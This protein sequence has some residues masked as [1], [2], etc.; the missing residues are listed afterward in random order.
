MVLIRFPDPQT[1]R[2]A[3]GFLSRHF[4]GKTWSSGQTLV[5]EAAIAHLKAEGIPFTIEGPATYE[6]QA[7]T[8]RNPPAA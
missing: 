8:V 6:Q 3:L 5:P 1:E 2:R 7:P 4:S